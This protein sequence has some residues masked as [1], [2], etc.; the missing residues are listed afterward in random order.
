[1]SSIGERLRSA[2]IKK[3][4]SIDDVVKV[5]NIR[6]FFLNAMEN[7]QFEELPEG[8]AYRRAFIKNYAESV[9]LD[10]EEIVNLYNHLM[11]Q[12]ELLKNSRVKDK[13]TPK[14]FKWL[15]KLFG[16]RARG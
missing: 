6:S 13:A 11:A 15:V 8:D 2:R 10:K 1:M 5:I 14:R 16:F 9:E 4:L 12:K 3:Q 7:N